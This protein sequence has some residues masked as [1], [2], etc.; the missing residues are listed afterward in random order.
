[1]ELHDIVDVI[2]RTIFAFVLFMVIAHFLGKQAI[3]QMTLHDFIAAV[4]LGAITGNLAFNI[5]MNFWIVFISL[6]LFGAIAYLLSIVSLKSRKARKWVSG[7]PTVLIQN[8]KILEGNLSKINYTLDY[9]NQALREKDIFDIDQVEYAI[10]EIDG[11]VSVMKKTPYQ[12][13]TKKDIGLLYPTP[14]HFPL[15]LIMD[16]NIVE[17]NLV[18]NNLSKVWLENI[19]QQRGLKLSDVC[20]AVRGTNLQVYI[21]TYDDHIISPT[22]KEQ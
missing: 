9:L 15:E 14:V 11:H 19:I 16:G 20:Y 18:E 2:I 7:E 21:D 17:K 1:M 12:N 6:V 22:D 5:E 13:I 4:T 10:L 3:S 8:G